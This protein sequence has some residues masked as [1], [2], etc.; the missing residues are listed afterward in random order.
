VP[1]VEK[2]IK[3]IITDT[4]IKSV[5]QINVTS[6]AWHFDEDFVG[7]GSYILASYAINALAGDFNICYGYS[8]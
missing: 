7:I 5:V 2:F 8:Y 4:V 3:L 1:I 6:A